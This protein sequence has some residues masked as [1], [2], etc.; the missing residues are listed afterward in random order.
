MDLGGRLRK[1]EGLQWEATE[2]GWRKG[3]TEAPVRRPPDGGACFWV[4][5]C[6]SLGRITVGWLWEGQ[7]PQHWP[8]GS[9]LNLP[10]VG[11]K[12]RHTGFSLEPDSSEGTAMPSW[13]F[14]I[15]RWKDISSFKIGSDVAR[16]VLLGCSLW[17]WCGVELGCRA[18]SWRNLQWPLRKGFWSKPCEGHWEMQL[19]PP[20][21]PR[22]R[23]TGLGERG[24][25][26]NGETDV[27]ICGV[28]KVKTPSG[29]LEYSSALGSGI[30]GREMNV[31]ISNV[32]RAA[33]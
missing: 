26:F 6:Y 10:V 19:H 15:W 23:N 2:S 14:L 12:G 20:A 3:S 29:Q 9:S 4:L 16:S 7:L 22:M 8:P 18:G 30:P 31:G 24:R 25:S 27:C 33:Y 21:L 17:Q 13:E 32:R 1:R 28:T 5:A 11:P